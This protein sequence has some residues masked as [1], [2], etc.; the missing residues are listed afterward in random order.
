VDSADG[1]GCAV[2]VMRVWIDSSDD[3][4]HVLNRLEDDDAGPASD[5]NVL[6][7]LVKLCGSLL[8]DLEELTRAPMTEILHDHA[9][10]RP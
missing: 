1:Y 6:C 4:D 5:R 2:D 3:I 7:G 8:L 10:R 9:R